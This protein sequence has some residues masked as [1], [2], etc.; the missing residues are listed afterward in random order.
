VFD[1]TAK[2][3]SATKYNLAAARNAFAAVTLKDG[4]VMV[5]GGMTGGTQADGLNGQAIGSCEI[6]ARQ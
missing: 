1:G 5:I 2:A 4:R 3:L 6:F